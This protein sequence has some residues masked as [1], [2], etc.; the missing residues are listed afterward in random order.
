MARKPNENSNRQK[1]LQ[2]AVARS[3]DEMNAAMMK[4]SRGKKPAKKG[5]K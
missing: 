4:A 5:K 1:A 3:A 2:G